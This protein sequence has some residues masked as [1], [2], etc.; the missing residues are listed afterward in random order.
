MIKTPAAQPL[1]F[2][3][4]SARIGLGV[5]LAF[6]GVSHLSFAR[7]EFLAQVPTFLPLDPALT[8]LLSGLA[9]IGLGLSLLTFFKM[10][11]AVGWIVAV[12]FI[13]VFPGNI[14]QWQEGK[15]AFGLDTDGKRLVRLAFQPVLV[16][17]ALWGTAAWR[18]RRQLRSKT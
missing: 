16:A 8:V 2:A 1:G 14:A 12:F 18:D 7:E 3:R 11:V 15:D 6:A 13:V 4:H 9:E 17:W 10:R 5:F